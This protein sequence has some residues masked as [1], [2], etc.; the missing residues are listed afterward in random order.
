[1]REKKE[2]I[3]IKPTPCEKLSE[4]IAATGEKVKGRL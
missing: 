2:K 3:K 4:G 1:M